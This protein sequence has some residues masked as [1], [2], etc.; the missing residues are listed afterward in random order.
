MSDLIDRL[1][2]IY[3]V[4]VNDGAGLLDGKDT[5]TRTFDVPPIN[6]EAVNELTTLRQ[7]LADMT[8]AKEEAGRK[9][10]GYRAFMDT[11]IEMLG[12]DKGRRLF[13]TAKQALEDTK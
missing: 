2:G 5:F 8:A 7:Q 13:V 12:E 4:Q 11:V 6:I 3:T 9:L 10:D 1:R